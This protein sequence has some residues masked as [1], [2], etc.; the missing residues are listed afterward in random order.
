MIPLKT[1]LQNPCRALS[2]PYW[3]AKNITIP[4]NMKIVHK[5]EFSEELLE[6]YENEVYF[7]LCHSMKELT[8][9]ELPGYDI[10]TALPKDIG[11]IVAVINNSY[12][13]LQV[14]TGQMQGYT[15]TPVYCPELW[16]LIKESETGTCVGC[17]IADFDAESE[18]LILE[19]IQ[20]LPEY[21]GRHIGAAIVRE[22]LWRGREFAKFATVSGKVN[23]A[24]KPELLYRNC[25]F[26]GEDIWHVL[27]KK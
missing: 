23:N 16:T 6:E 19:W 17:G 2:I 7:R 4:D 12:D 9:P 27:H 13:D 20:V 14:S 22:L 8:K 15:K 11:T 25:G 1:Y 5:D 18:E 26:T 24:T 10:V 3:K 21:R